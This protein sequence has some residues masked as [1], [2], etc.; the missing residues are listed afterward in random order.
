MEVRQVG[1]GRV[2]RRAVLDQAALAV[3]PA[4]LRGEFE[5]ELVRV[6]GGSQA[7]VRGGGSVAESVLAGV[8]LSQARLGPLMLTDAVFTQVDLSGAVLHEVTARR[9][10]L[11]RCRAMG[12]RLEFALVSDVYAE[13]CRFDYGS[14]H[15][16]RVKGRLAFRECT[17]REATIAGDLSDAVFLDCDFAGAEFDAGAA[18]GCDLRS[19]RLVGARG[20]LSLRGAM[21]TADQ[22]VSVAD[23]LAAEAGLTVA[24]P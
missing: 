4:A 24:R 2:V 16:A 18:K 15:V 12:V 23:Q 22:A 17:F 11:L 14:L 6:D 21:I 10:E 7:G 1:D 5:H 19:S 3:G 9:V 8:D 13:G 20:L